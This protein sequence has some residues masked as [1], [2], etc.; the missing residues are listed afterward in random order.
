M[1]AKIV[2]YR[3]GWLSPDHIRPAVPQFENIV[4]LVCAYTNDERPPTRS[5]LLLLMIHSE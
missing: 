4:L 3:R 5:T 1:I 2:T